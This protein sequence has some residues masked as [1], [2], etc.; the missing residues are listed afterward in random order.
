M[1]R[2]WRYKAL[3]MLWC[4]SEYVQY[5]AKVQNILGFSDDFWSNVGYFQQIRVRY[6]YVGQFLLI[7]C[8]TA[9]AQHS[10]TGKADDF[11]IKF[12]QHLIK[13]HNLARI[14]PTLTQVLLCAES[15][16][17]LRPKRFWSDLMSTDCLKIVHF[18]QTHKWIAVS[19]LS[20]DMLSSSWRDI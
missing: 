3:Y 4:I 11:N 13:H 6:L 9:E 1:C 5:L 7:Y 14:G 12:W 17:V 8:I 18:H 19:P 15:S 16:S 2:I 10:V 20:T